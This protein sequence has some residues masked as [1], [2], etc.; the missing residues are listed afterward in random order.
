M[1]WRKWKSQNAISHGVRST[2]DN[3]YCVMYKMIKN[4]T[5]GDTLRPLLLMK[6]LYSQYKLVGGRRFL[7]SLYRWTEIT[8]IGRILTLGQKSYL[9]IHQHKI[10]NQSF[11]KARYFNPVCPSSCHDSPKESLVRGETR[12]RCVSPEVFLQVCHRILHESS[13]YF[14]PSFLSSNPGI[15]LW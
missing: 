1:D 15:A 9:T 2:Y 12:F 10:V 4:V 6:Q 8:N 13:Y 3:T 14:S 5:W 7:C 11:T